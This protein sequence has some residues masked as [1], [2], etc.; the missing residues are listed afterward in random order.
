MTLS[1]RQQYHDL[2][3]T[4]LE[5]GADPT[6]LSIENG[7]SPFHAAFKIGLSQRGAYISSLVYKPPNISL[8][9]GLQ[10]LGTIHKHL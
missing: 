10:H 2:I 1:Q 7:D 8:M 9:F 5:N 3:F 4:L 6:K